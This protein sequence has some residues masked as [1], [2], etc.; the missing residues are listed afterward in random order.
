MITEPCPG[1]QSSPSVYNN[2]VASQHIATNLH[3]QW[4]AN[5]I[6][7]DVGVRGDDRA[8]S[9]VHPLPHHVL[10]KQPLFLLKN[11]GKDLV[12][13]HLMKYS[14]TMIASVHIML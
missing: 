2:L 5:L 12:T 6:H 9:I 1:S 11:L 4:N 3:Y 13:E 7:V 14:T 8:S 10:T